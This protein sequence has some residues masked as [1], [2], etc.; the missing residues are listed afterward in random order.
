MYD[1]VIVGAGIAGL[2]AARLLNKSGKKICIIEKS[3]RIGGLIH[4]KHI[5]VTKKKKPKVKKKNK[6]LKNNKKNK[7]KY[8]AGGAVVYSY[9]KNMV[10]LIKE[11]NINT[12]TLPIDRK[13]LYD[14]HHKDFWDGKPRKAPLDKRSTNRYFLLLD[15]LFK[16]MKSKGD[17]YCRKFTL[18]QIALEILSFEDVRF[19]EFCYG[20][21][22]EFR[23][24]NSVVAK[25]NIENE[26]FNSK[27]IFIFKK[28]YI[29]I[30]KA[31]YNSIKKDVKLIKKCHLIK[32]QK[33]NNYY[34]LHTNKSKLKTKKIIFAIPK[35]ALLKMCHSFTEKEKEMFNKV[36][37][38]SLTRIFAQYDMKKKQ[39]Q[40]MKKLNFSTVDNPIRQI[41]PLR[42]KLGI[43]QISYTD[44]YFADFW[45]SLSIDNT[46]KVLKK[47][48]SETF[49]YEKIDNPK[50]IWKHY[51]KDAEHSWRPNVNEKQIYKKILH[52]RKNVFII[53]ES[54]SLNQGWAEG[55]IQTSIDACKIIN[56]SKC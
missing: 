36:K 47:L 23:L 4:T 35:E 20:Y 56:K 18:E 33:H 51:W 16:Y 9:Q 38:Y 5:N 14:R 28:G 22:N 44:W 7:I 1:I 32:F 41:I 48:L 8:E 11:F 52:L 49:H 10:K 31:I 40:W 2:N 29:D 26:L 55:A 17:S 12:H 50:K 6:T 34:E 54:F 53:G 24:A 21:A 3:N 42:K 39:N 43:F 27:N 30:P 25:K 46:K 45:G 19:I 37:G 15:K 13:G